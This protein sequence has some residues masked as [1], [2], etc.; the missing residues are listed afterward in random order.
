MKSRR[1]FLKQMSKAALAA[2]AAS[3]LLSRA[4]AQGQ[5]VQ[6]PGED[7]MI[8]RSF[9]FVDLETPVEYLN[10]WLTP[11]PHFF[12][13]NHMHEPSQLDA[14]DWRL[15]VG[16]EIAKPITLTLSELAKLESHS[17]VNT[18]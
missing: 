4:P 6:F 14:G 7:G 9:R 8:L 5:S 1:E 17:V 12:V 15:T 10:T 18:L 3:S 16:G 2:G 11:V 13:R